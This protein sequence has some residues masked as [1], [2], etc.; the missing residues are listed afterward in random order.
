MLA[1]F[2]I[3]GLAQF[4]YTLWQTQLGGSSLETVYRG[5]LLDQT[6]DGNLIII[7]NT[8]SN[9]GDVVGNH[10]SRDVWALKTDVYGNFLWQKCL[11]GSSV[12][13]GTSV[14]ATSDGGFVMCGMSESTNGDLLENNG[15]KDAWILKADADGNVE[16]SQVVGGPTK[17]VFMM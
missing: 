9:D 6:T 3:V 10:G 17:T 8:Q 16:W 15:N 7:V 1:A 2:S 11:G 4:P 5:D 12:D 14:Q 13:D